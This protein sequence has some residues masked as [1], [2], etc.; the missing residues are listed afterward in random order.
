MSQKNHTEVNPWQTLSTKEIYKNEWMRLREDLVI[1]PGGKKGVYGVV[2]TSP[3]IGIVPIT[4]TL[5]TLLVAD[6][7]TGQDAVNT[8]REFNQ[9]LE[10]NGVCL[11]K[12]DGDARGGAA[13]S[14]RQVTGKPIKYI[15]VGEKLDALE[16]FHPDRMASRILG[17]GDIV[18][19]VEKTQQNI[20][21]KKA[22]ELEK[23]L[24]KSEFTFDDFFD[25]LGRTDGALCVVGV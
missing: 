22:K 11:T 3:A 5:E 14:I 16:M 2:E 23:K 13:L 24:R 4:E 18:S 6:S 21:D 15:G 10:F 25:L 7:L 19:L 1:T 8:A 20:D 9:R 17:M 12:M